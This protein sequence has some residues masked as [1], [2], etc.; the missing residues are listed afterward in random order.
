[1]LSSFLN[2]LRHKPFLFGAHTTVHSVHTKQAFRGN[3]ASQNGNFFRVILKLCKP[4][5]GHPTPL[6]QKDFL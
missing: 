1:M 6:S 4:V 3:V 5:I 2:F